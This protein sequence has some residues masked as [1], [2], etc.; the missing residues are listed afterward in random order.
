[1]LIPGMDVMTI[2]G[3]AAGAGVVVL[4]GALGDVLPL[5][6]VRST[7]RESENQCPES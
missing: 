1:M 4:E 5:A 7:W 6:P 2:G 3:V